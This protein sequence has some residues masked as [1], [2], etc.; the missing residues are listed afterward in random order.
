M[1]R[2][3][4]WD[5][6]D[7]ILEGPSLGSAPDS[8]LADMEAL[9]I[10]DR[11]GISS[12]PQM[13]VMDPRTERVIGMPERTVESVTGLFETAG[14]QIDRPGA[15]VKKLYRRL[16]KALRLHERGKWSEGE[17]L[18]DELSRTVDPWLIWLAASRMKRALAINPRLVT[19]DREEAPDIDDPDPSWRA[20]TL[21]RWLLT[22]EEKVFGMPARPD[23]EADL[24]RAMLSDEDIVVRLRA[25]RCLALQNPSIIGEHAADL[26][27][28][29]NDPFRYEVLSHIEQNPD[30]TLGPDLIRIFR[31]AGTTI[32]SLNPNVLR[33]N[34][35]RCLRES[36]D[37]SGLEE[38]LAEIAE[39]NPRNYL[40]GLI[41][42]TAAD[43]AARGDRDLL[44]N[45]IARFLTLFPPALSGMEDDAQVAAQELRLAL[46]FCRKL[47]AALI[48]LSGREDLPE[49]PVEWSEQ[50]R[51]GYIAEL[52]RLLGIG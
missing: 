43:I 11:F 34:T 46:A 3:F 28:V 51:S 15:E 49:P 35:V 4:G 29:P 32:P 14:D 36:G 42:E 39:P 40:H 20:F 6:R 25:L 17:H 22:L 5:H 45:T 7:E 18:L 2:N 8:L 37:E 13:I 38:L 47:R 10:H 31:G 24:T 23:V 21:E 26:L 50:S 9:R 27:K 30:T 33:I 16:D 12:W 52:Q 1:N 44:R 48:S 41:V 19:G